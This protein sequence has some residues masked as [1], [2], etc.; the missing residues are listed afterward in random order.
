MTDYQDVDSQLPPASL[1]RLVAF[2]EAEKRSPGKSRLG[3]RSLELLEA[4]LNEPQQVSL[5]GI[6]QLAQAHGVNPSTLTRLARRLGF[7]G[8][9]D[10]Q[11]I[12][13]EDIAQASRFYSSQA[14]RLL[15]TRDAGAL[16]TAKDGGPL[17]DLCN[18]E[19]NNV[20]VT[21]KSIDPAQLRSIARSVAEARRVYVIGLRGCY[22]AAHYLGYYLGFL[23]ADVVTLGS[24]GFTVAE[25]LCAIGPGDVFIAITLHPETRH[26]L[27]SCRVARELGA[28]VVTISNHITS[29]VRVYGD[30]N[31]TVQSQGPFYFNPVAALFVL[32][33]ALVAQIAED[34]GAEAIGMLKQ[35]ER[36]FDQLDIE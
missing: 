28:H 18:G 32:L 3:R 34:M 12:F 11:K 1:E 33:E 25:D 5:H 6:S 27:E 19:L 17:Q 9:K 7:G 22:S 20:V 4:L 35:R 16:R 8:F 36:V 30:D 29:P 23:R 13:R 24:A 26:T 31:L 10:F 15:G 14:A 2:L 21:I